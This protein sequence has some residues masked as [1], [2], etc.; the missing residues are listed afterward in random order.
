[1]GTSVTL[2]TNTGSLAKTGF[3][4]NGWNTNQA[5]TGDHYDAGGSY[6]LGTS[7][8][9]LYAEWLAAGTTYTVGGTISFG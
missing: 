1:M 2:A 7:A 5:G 8:V 4:F 9:T 6:S 3:T